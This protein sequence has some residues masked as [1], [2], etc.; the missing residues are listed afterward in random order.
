V[1]AGGHLDSWVAG[2]G[3]ADNGAGSAMVMEAA[4]IIA[5]TG[6]RP[7]RTIRFA[8]WAGEEQGLL[9]SLSYVESHL[10]TRGNPSDP[11]QTGLALYMG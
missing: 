5:K 6:I 3:A 1:M 9:G 4:R 7:K 8:L 10:A 2:D 11:K